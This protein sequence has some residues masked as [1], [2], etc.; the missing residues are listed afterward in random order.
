MDVANQYRADPSTTW[1]FDKLWTACVCKLF[2]ADEHEEEEQEH[3]HLQ[4]H[5]QEQEQEQEQGMD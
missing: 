3:V 2:Y 1:G 5:E 4:D